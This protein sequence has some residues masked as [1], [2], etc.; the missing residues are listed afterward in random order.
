MKVQGKT[1]RWWLPLII[2]P[3]LLGLACSEDST[4]PPDDPPADYPPATTLDQLLQNFKRA[5]SEMNSKE[6][7]LL[8]DD[9][10]VFAFDPRDVGPDEPWQ[11]ETWGRD[12]ELNCVERICGGEPNIHW[13]WVDKC[14]LDFIAGQPVTSPM[15][16]DW[17]MVVL[18]AIDL[19]IH[20]TQ[21]PSGDQWLLQTP[22]SY[23]AHLHLVQREVNRGTQV[24]KIIVW[25]DKPPSAVRSSLVTGETS[26]GAI[27]ASFHTP[28]NQ[29]QSS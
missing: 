10:F 9:D 4:K 24:W 26:W 7:A 5:C 23:E 1:E 29:D 17:M 27:K 19:A 3:L 21:Q 2:L 15:N 12:E 13:C 25:E 18:T 14:E 20:T 16:P 8:I 6:Y 11:E 22:G 28:R